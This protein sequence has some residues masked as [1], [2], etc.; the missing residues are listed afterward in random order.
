MDLREIRAFLSSME[1]ISY[2]ICVIFAIFGSFV[3]TFGRDS[4]TNV[5]EILK[6][7][8]TTSFISIILILFC[9]IY[10]IEFL[11]ML[12]ICGLSGYVGDKA[13]TYMSSKLGKA[14]SSIGFAI[15]DFG[16]NIEQMN[17]SDNKKEDKK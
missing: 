11:Y 1:F 12:L 9:K 8:L 16:K 2:F 17:I 15:I 10:E 3:K 4:V 6:Q 14:I 7:V 5:L 13:L